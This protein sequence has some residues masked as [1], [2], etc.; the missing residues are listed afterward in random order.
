MKLRS[1]KMIRTIWLGLLVLL[2]SGATIAYFK[3]YKSIQTITPEMLLAERA[4][5]SSTTFGLAS[6]NLMQLNLLE[7]NWIEPS[8]ESDYAKFDTKNESWKERLS[9]AG[10]DPRK[11]LHYLVAAIDTDDA[12]LTSSFI[13]VGKFKSALVKEALKKRYKLIEEKMDGF[14]LLSYQEINKETCD[15]ENPRAFYISDQFIIWSTPKNLQS[16]LE[17]LSTKSPPDV[18]KLKWE[19]YRK[20]KILSA[21]LTIPKVQPKLTGMMQFI[22]TQAIVEK[23]NGFERAYLGI[24]IEW[25]KLAGVLNLQAD[26]NKKEQVATILLH[27]QNLLNDTKSPW[28]KKL[29]SLNKLLSKISFNSDLKHFNMNVDIDLD[30]FLLIKEIPKEFV[31]NFFSGLGASVS[32][33]GQANVEDDIDEQPNKLIMETSFSSLPK[34]DPLGTFSGKPLPYETGPLGFSI[35]SVKLNDENQKDQEIE[36]EYYGVGIPNIQKNELVSLYFNE[37]NDSEGKNL[38]KLKSSCNINSGVEPSHPIQFS[39]HN[40]LPSFRGNHSIKLQEGA[41]VYSVATIKGEAKIKVPTK[42]EIQEIYVEVGQKIETQNFALVVNKVSKTSVSINIYGDDTYIINIDGLNKDGKK[43]TTSGSI[44]NTR[45]FYGEGKWKNLNFRGTVVKLRVYLVKEAKDFTVPF[46]LMLK[47]DIVDVISSPPIFEKFPTTKMFEEIS[48]EEFIKKFSMVGGAPLDSSIEDYIKLKKTNSEKSKLNLKTLMTGPFTLIWEAGEKDSYTIFE[49]FSNELINSRGT[50]SLEVKLLQIETKEGKILYPPAGPQDNFYYN[51]WIRKDEMSVGQYQNVPNTNEFLKFIGPSRRFSFSGLPD[52]LKSQ[53]VKKIK[54]LIRY[55]LVPKIETRTIEN[56]KLG[57]TLF[58][59]G[60]EVLKLI[61]ID[62]QKFTYAYNNKWGQILG[63][64]NFDMTNREMER[65]K[66]HTEKNGLSIYRQ[67]EVTKTK[68]FFAVKEEFV[69]YPFEI[70][71]QSVSPPDTSGG[72]I[73]PLKAQPTKSVV[74]PNTVTIIGDR[75]FFNKALTSVV[76]P[77]SV[78]SIGV[79]AFAVN[80]LTSVVIP[81]SVTSIGSYAFYVNALTSLV[82]PNSVTSIGSSAFAS[83]Q[84]TSIVIPNS[85]TSIGSFAFSSNQLTSVVI[86]IS[87]TSIGDGAF[88]GNKLTSVVIPA[89]VSIGN[90][91]SMGTY[92]EAF[93]TLYTNP[94]SGGA[95]TYKYVQGTGW[96]KQP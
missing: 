16:I 69:D 44:N 54:G 57:S 65:Q 78:T 21:M 12:G 58:E 40:N 3:Y 8:D 28:R 32:V 31:A 51:P 70:E 55:K 10:I 72:N 83:N 41:Q 39:E 5:Y 60:Q 68:L 33:S 30:A 34:F 15:L 61:E 19:N 75:E 86:P 7:K 91:E 25:F 80:Q 92:G 53:D 13:L 29:P 76:I 66:T 59:D 74:I 24:N 18:D 26:F 90:N 77:I 52:N 35:T 6:L 87:V 73:H 27:L 49:I 85:V 1:K 11:D 71:T 46:E 95:G 84:L 82:I 96:R 50:D 38:I 4:I 9:D 81:N 2:L 94:T 43:L 23:L 56:P 88:Y 62:N 93:K 64:Q 17:R 89:N 14:T 20:N 79:E 63:V 67:K 22:P 37:A 45:I 48:K 36:I 47:E 42:V